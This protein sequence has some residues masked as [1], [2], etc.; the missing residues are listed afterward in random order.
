MLQGTSTAIERMSTCWVHAG[1]TVMNLI[2]RM[3]SSDGLATGNEPVTSAQL[4][5]QPVTVDNPVDS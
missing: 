3:R 4:V 1:T 2:N 5:S